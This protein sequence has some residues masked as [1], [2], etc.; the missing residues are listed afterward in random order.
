MLKV[1][2]MYIKDL[3]FALLTLKF[4]TLV[5]RFT[6]LYNFLMKGYTELEVMDMDDAFFSWFIPRIVYFREHRRGIPVGTT[7][8]KWD[9]T[10]ANLHKYAVYSQNLLREG[11]YKDDKG[12]YHSWRESPHYK[13]FQYLFTKYLDHLWF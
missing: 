3:I 8:Y 2:W 5:W 10:L 6:N 11:Y 12:E 9:K 7:E 13:K 1:L 4:S